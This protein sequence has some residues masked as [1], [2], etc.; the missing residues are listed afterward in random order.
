MTSTHIAI[1][2]VI[3]LWTYTSK[4]LVIL[5]HYIMGCNVCLS[6]LTLRQYV[7]LFPYNLVLKSVQYLFRTGSGI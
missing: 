7:T 1:P 5:K 3:L 6:M 2:D 4:C